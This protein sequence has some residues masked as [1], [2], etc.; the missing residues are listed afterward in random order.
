MLIREVAGALRAQMRSGDLLG[1][2][3]GDEFVVLLHNVTPTI[4]RERAQGLL[5]AVENCHHVIG[6]ERYGTTASI[7]LV[8]FQPDQVEFAEVLSQADA[9][10]FNAKEL[11][12]D[13][14]S[15]AGVAG[16]AAAD[17]AS[18]M[19]WTIRIREAL[20]NRGFLLYA[21][22]IA[23]LRP[24]MDT[25]A[26]FE[27]LLRMRDSRGG[28]PHMP[29]RFIPA[30]ERF[31]LA[32]RIDREVVRLALERLEAHPAAA[33]TVALCAINLSAATLMDDG[34][35]GFVAER[36]HRSDVPAQHLCF[37]MTETSAMRD[38]ARV[39]RVIDELRG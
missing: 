15:I 17:P 28:T 3:G 5:H 13:R 26:H 38:P 12:G 1:H 36:L 9:A 32:V 4:A 35:V 6:E 39:Q 21:Q 31:Q 25:G 33:R 23:P 16:G 22:S 34:F 27:L 18:G 37:E 11:G 14:I 20:Q 19:R 7:G 10:C 29:E 2:L 8:P 24:D 30:A